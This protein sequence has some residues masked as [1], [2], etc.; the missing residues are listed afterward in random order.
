MQIVQENH[1]IELCCHAVTYSVGA[2]PFH[3]H[4]NYEICRPLNYPCRFRIDGEIVEAQPYDIVVIKDK[5]VHQFIVDKD[6]TQVQIIQFHPK[7]VMD[8]VAYSMQLPIHIERSTIDKTIGLPERIDSVISLME[9]E[10][11]ELDANSN[12]YF[13]ALESA[14]YFL[15]TRHFGINVK[16]C[17]NNS[18]SDFYTAVKY[19]NENFCEPIT[20]SSVAEGLYLSRVKLSSMFKKYAGISLMSY[21]Y[22]LR[23]KNANAL[24]KNG[25]TVT[26]AAFASG[27]GSIRTF[28]SVY[29]KIM[30]MSPRD[31][32]R[33]K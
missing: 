22:N 1:G 24:M 32:V 33:N 9:L 27:F 15:L 12:G 5:T 6:G 13:R 8:S 21:V 4:E 29:K 14:F 23:I 11:E 20:V 28:N 31:Y 10:K 18:R 7:I 3:W 30:G 26:D 25:A 16:S 2:Q 17:T 19:I